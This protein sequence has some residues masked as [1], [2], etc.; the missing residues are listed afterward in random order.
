MF[1]RENRKKNGAPQP[2]QVAASESK[3][4]NAARK[5]APNEPIG[6]NPEDLRFTPDM[7]NPAA[8]NEDHYQGGLSGAG[9]YKKSYEDKI[10]WLGSDHDK[11][12]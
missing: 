4:Q 1:M 2:E 8:I 11:H 6:S 10:L 12:P 7:S 3:G 9:V 5:I